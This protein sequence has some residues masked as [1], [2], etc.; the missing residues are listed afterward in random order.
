MIGL[1]SI[2]RRMLGSAFVLQRRYLISVQ[3]IPLQLHV[4]VLSDYVPVSRICTLNVA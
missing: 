4:Q 1:Q 3:L 2:V